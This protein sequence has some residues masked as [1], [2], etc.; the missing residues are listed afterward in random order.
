MAPA[1]GIQI[2][3]LRLR[4]LVYADD[5]CLM[6]SSPEH[7][8]ALIDALSSYCAILHMEISILKTKVMVVS[9]VPAPAVAFSCNGNPVEQDIF[10]ARFVKPGDSRKARQELATMQQNDMSVETYAAQV[11]NC[12]ARIAASKVGTPVGSTTQATYFLKGLKRLILFNLEG[13]V[14][15]DVMQ[16]IHK[17]IDAAEKV[18]ANLDMS[19]KQ[20]KGQNQEQPQ[21][22]RPRGSGCGQANYVDRNRGDNRRRSAPYPTHGCGHGAAVNAVQALSPQEVQFNAA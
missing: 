2:R 21:S 20:A 16:D 22:E 19:T 6:A 4:E 8:Q 15:P 7:L 3:H 13:M 12:A 9:P 5:I 11:R 10:L 1:A 17:L 18:E 14:S